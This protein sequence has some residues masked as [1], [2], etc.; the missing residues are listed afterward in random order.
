MTGPQFRE[1]LYQLALFC[2]ELAAFAGES[3]RTLARWCAEHA[4]LHAV[5]M[6]DAAAG[7][8]RGGATR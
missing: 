6:A 4:P 7:M 3:L 8:V 1:H 5:R 2:H